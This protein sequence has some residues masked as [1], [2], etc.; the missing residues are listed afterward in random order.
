MLFT[1]S[2]A[3]CDPMA[4]V[5]AKSGT[6][7]FYDEAR[8]GS[9]PVA[10]FQLAPSTY[11]DGFIGGPSYSPVTN[12]VYVNVSSSNESLYPP[13]M[14]AIDP[15][16]GHPSIKWHATFGPDSYAAGSLNYPGQPRG[17]PA[18]SAGG[19]V[20]VGTICTPSGNTCG[21]TTDSVARRGAAAAT[22]NGAAA[23]RKPLICC[24]PAGTGGGALW[25]LDASTGTVLNGGNP[26]I[27][28]PG[29]I[30]M[31]PTIDGN[32]LYVIDNTG[33]MYG[34][35]IDPS[36]PSIEATMHSVDSRMLKVWES[37]PHG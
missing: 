26:L 24:A 21:A 31:A 3:G 22:K 11:A 37:A 23:Q 13:G 25:A 18:A 34:L 6:I 12:L 14:V 30:R 36:Y 15:G 32:W 19:V 29:P 9:G 5:Q 2:G 16:C 17:I 27:I 1:P 33:D 10:Q 4:A 35:T 28:T 8:V 7:F 20:F